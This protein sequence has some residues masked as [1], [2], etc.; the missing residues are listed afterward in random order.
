[1]PSKKPKINQ[2]V[3]SRAV[4][5]GRPKATASTPPAK[6]AVYQLKITLNDIRPPI[7][8]RVQTKDCTL[9][10]LHR[11][12]RRAWAG[13]TTT[14]IGSTSVANHVDRRGNEPCS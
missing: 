5:K 8:R 4:S 1:M 7:W 13:G 10:K 9:F 12:F 11:S 14:C 2:N 3:L 6:S